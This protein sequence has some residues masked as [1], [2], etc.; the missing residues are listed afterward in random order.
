[1]KKGGGGQGEIKL[2]HTVQGHTI[3]KDTQTK[4]KTGSVFDS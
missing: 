4:L 1:M 2:K 3:A